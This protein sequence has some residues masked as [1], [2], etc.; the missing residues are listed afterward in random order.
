MS[1]GWEWWRKAICCLFE[2]VKAV[3]V[4]LV[5]LLLLLLL[6]LLQVLPSD[7]KSQR[8]D[9]IHVFRVSWLRGCKA[10]HRMGWGGSGRRQA[11]LRCRWMWSRGDS[12]AA[13]T[14]ATAIGASGLRVHVCA[15]SVC[16][17]LLL[18]P[19]LLVLPVGF[20]RR[21]LALLMSLPLLLI[22]ATTKAL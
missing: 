14:T 9:L 19:L 13:A 1:L 18:L 5:P 17:V 15:Q 22:T 6:L 16:E 10:N 7:V 20:L 21:D 3:L 8:R 12:A 2:T 4:L 11:N